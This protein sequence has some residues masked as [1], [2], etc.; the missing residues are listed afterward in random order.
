MLSSYVLIML[1]AD[2]GPLII[3]VAVTEEKII[4]I[5]IIIK[6]CSLLFFFYPTNSYGIANRSSTSF[7]FI[8]TSLPS[9]GCAGFLFNSPG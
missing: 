4:I 9:R 8:L 5:I 2:H 1:V 3:V 6:T 7:P